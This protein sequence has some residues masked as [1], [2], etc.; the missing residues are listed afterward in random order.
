M[1]LLM[2]N[3]ITFNK[4]IAEKTLAMVGL[5]VAVGLAT[6]VGT[7]LGVLLGGVESLPV[8]N[9]AA[10]TVLVTLLG[11]MFG[12]LALAIGA[13]TGRSRLASGVTAGV[14]LLSYFMF[15]FFP[16]SEA[17]E[18][19]ASLSPFTLYLGSDPLTNG[20]AWGDATI[21]AV[22]FLVLVAI[23]PRLIARRDLRG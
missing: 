11:L 3:P 21:L 16:L 8:G 19:W 9:I 22:I 15:S 4:I 13:A 5:T 20:M 23:S 2:G 1:G 14:A 10:T 12:G 18:G 7:W 6:F 17:F